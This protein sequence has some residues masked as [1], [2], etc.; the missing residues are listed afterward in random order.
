L[1][2]EKKSLR[3]SA[4][5]PWNKWCLTLFTTQDHHAAIVFLVKN[6]LCSSA[7][8][9]LRSTYEGYIRGAWLAHCATDEDVQ[10]FIR[11]A[12]PPGLGLLIATLEK[13]PEFD[14][15]TLSRLK[16]Q[17]WIT[18]CDYA[19]VG[20]R[21]VLRWIT[22]NGIT[23]NFKSEE[24]D[25]VLNVSGVLALLASVEIAQLNEDVALAECILEKCKAFS[26]H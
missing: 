26:W 22:E 23:P 8:C 20:G 16:S 24:I 21:L 2:C 14:S 17:A 6:G 7:F 19:H 15:K 18:L 3:L 4:R 5:R 12:E 25:E 13:R 10:S 9:L 1:I 11:G